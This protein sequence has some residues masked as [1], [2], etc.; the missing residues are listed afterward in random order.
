MRVRIGFE[1][2]DGSAAIL[3]AI[4][5]HLIMTILVETCSATVM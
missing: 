3:T 5:K 1:F 2:V 4:S